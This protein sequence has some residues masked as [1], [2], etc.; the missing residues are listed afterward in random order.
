MKIKLFILLLFCLTF[1]TDGL[2]QNAF[3]GAE[4][5]GSDTRHAYQT[6]VAPKILTVTTL[7]DGG[8]GSLRWAVNQNYPRII[9][10][11]VSGV[12][13]LY[14]DLYIRNPYIF[15]A[16][17]SAPQPGVTISNATLFVHTHDVLIQNI[18]LRYGVNSRKQD[19]LTIA[20]VRDS[21]YNVI[22]DHCSISWGMDENIGIAATQYGITI[23]NCI[24]S[25][26]IDTKGGNAYGLL[27]YDNGE[28]SVLKNLFVHNADRNPLVKGESH[29]TLVYNNVIYNSDT[30]CIY[31]GHRENGN[32]RFQIAAL[33]NYYVPGIKNRNSN[34]ITFSER[35]SE[36]AV[37]YLSGNQVKGKNKPQWQRG[38]TYN[39]AGEQIIAQSPMFDYPHMDLIPTD[40][41]LNRVLA[42]CGAF[43]QNRDAIDE[44]IIKDV[45][46]M[47]GKWIFHEDEVG[48]YIEQAACHKLIIP[49]TPHDDDNNNG[50]TN[51]EDWL[52]S[53][54][55]TNNQTT[56]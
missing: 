29:K 10:F 36:N 4:G 17:Q 49:D 55:Y 21:S 1:A 11:E 56:K 44:R 26:A 13:K 23:S 50:F 52:N 45:T 39:Q 20:S 47:T 41:L 33:N 12:I 6:G 35:I 42:H 15:I 43:P 2:S 9:I 54:I 5:F 40:S 31:F 51:I 28:L 19:C 53:L 34:I 37:A 38:I 3:P 48:G 18:K 7:K 32:S 27:A 24:I 14:R 8:I 25:E 30:H 22:V 46:H 16:G